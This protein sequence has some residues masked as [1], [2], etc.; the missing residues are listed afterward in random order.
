MPEQTPDPKRFDVHTHPWLRHLDRADAP[1]VLEQLTA[2]VMRPAFGAVTKK[3]FELKLFELLYRNAVEAG[4]VTLGE[5]AE[6]LTITRARA[7]SLVLESRTRFGA[8]MG[9]EHRKTILKN[10]VNKWNEK[11]SF[12]RDGERLRVVVD[13]PFVRDILK[14]YAYEHAIPM[15][16]SFAG[17]V[18]SF[19]W[20][21]YLRLVRSLKDEDVQ[22]LDVDV[23]REQLKDALGIEQ[24]SETEFDRQIDEVANANLSLFEKVKRFGKMAAQLGGSAGSVYKAIESGVS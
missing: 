1:Q 4:D 22:V 5:I 10:A 13:D 3:E 9:A 24:A 19:T 15:D 14:N 17:E 23:I 21:T 6:D 8:G 11:L 18:M 2:F 20:P 7:R 16:G 12:E